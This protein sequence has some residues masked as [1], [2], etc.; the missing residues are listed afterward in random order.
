MTDYRRQ[1]FKR[2]ALV[3]LILAA[4][5][6]DTTLFDPMERQPKFKAFA[7]NSQYEDGRAMRQP[8]AGTV[9]RET[10][11]MRPEI[12]LGT[13]RKGAIVSA[14]RISGARD[15]ARMC[16]PIVVWVFIITHSSASSRPG[17]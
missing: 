5:C 13:D 1:V 16:A 2:T 12:T 8:P 7:A 4:G 15:P 10:I 6:G 14:I 17:L 11:T 9:P 3:A